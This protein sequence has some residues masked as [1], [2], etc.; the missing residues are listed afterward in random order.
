MSIQHCDQRRMTAEGCH[1]ERR[2]VNLSKCGFDSTKANGGSRGGGAV[3]V[4]PHTSDL[5]KQAV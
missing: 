3:V 1:S 5:K 2:A 4:R